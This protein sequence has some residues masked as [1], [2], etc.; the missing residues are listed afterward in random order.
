M[1]FLNIRVVLIVFFTLFS[2][3]LIAQDDNTYKN[4]AYKKTKYKK[5]MVMALFDPPTYRKRV[6][7]ELV[8]QLR[9]RGIKA[10]PSSE[11][12]TNEML[13]DS[14]NMRRTAEENGVDG[15]VIVRYLGYATA[16]QDA[17]HYNGSIYSIVGEFATFDLETRATKTGLMQ[18]DF[19]IPNV[20]GTQYRT[21]IPI[22]LSNGADLA[23]R[24][25]SYN[26]RKKLTGDKI[27]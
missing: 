15:A 22:Q 9:D 18:V 26:T 23:V 24:E 10:I 16:V 4:P 6:E 2:G 5:V 17:V 11:I 13:K 8:R 14:A 27:L 21:G 20:I 12:F 7:T 25:F 1:K 19:Y 3:N